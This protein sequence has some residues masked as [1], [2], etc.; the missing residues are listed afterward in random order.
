MKITQILPCF[1][2][3]AN[4]KWI[5]LAKVESIEVEPHIYGST[6]RIKVIM[7][8]KSFHIIKDDFK[9]EQSAK[10]YIRDLLNAYKNF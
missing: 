9:T 5:D 6:F 3:C 1:L 7:L 4:N 10:R 8:S 2:E